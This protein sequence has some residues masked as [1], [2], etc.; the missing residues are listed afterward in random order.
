MKKKSISVEKQDGSALVLAIFT[1]VLLTGMGTALLFLSQHEARMAQASLRAKKAFFLAEAGLEDGRGTLFALNG[2]NPFSDDLDTTAGADDE[3][4]FDAAAIEA[5]YDG[6]GNVTGFTGFDDDVPLRPLTAFSSSSDP[7]WYIAFLTND[8]LETATNKTDG[9]DRV[10]ITGVGA[11][12]DRS[13]EVVQAIIEPFQPLPPVPPAAITMLGEDPVFDNGS[14]GAQSHTGSDC[15]IPGGPFAPIVGTISSS[16]NDAVQQV[17][18]DNRPEAFTSGSGSPPYEGPGT[19]GNLNDPLDPIVA[20]AGHGTIDPMWTD[21]QA[22]KEMVEGLA[23]RSFYYCNTDVESCSF[24]V[25][26]PD[27]IVFVD[28]DLTS[29]PGSA[30]S[31]VLVVTG[32]LTYHGNTEWNGIVMVIGEGSILRNGGGN[33]NPSGAMIVANIDPTPDGP[34]ADKSDWC[35]TPPDGFG[36]ATYHTNG[37]G[38][39]TVTWCTDYIDDANPVTSY[40]VTEFVQR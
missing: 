25:T 36:Q 12:R 38:N 13:L 9:N 15:G 39:S 14:S 37:G 20:A 34:N 8:P 21:C 3:I 5:V 31:G 24:P 16:A 6:D 4:D 29:G 19:I 10:M 23:L 22:L 40:R 27:S 11:G 7:G 35:T 18:E 17:V 30:N 32:H 28:G 26:T 2:E 1:L 33:G